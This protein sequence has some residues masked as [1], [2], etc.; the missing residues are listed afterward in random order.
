MYFQRSNRF[1]AFLVALTLAITPATSDAKKPDKPGG[2]NGGGGD[3]GGGDTAAYEYVDLLGFENGS[4]GYQS[5]AK[6]VLNRDGNGTLMILGDSFERYEDL[7]YQENPAIWFVAPDGTFAEPLNL[8]TPASIRQAEPEGFNP[9]G[10]TVVRTKVA[11]EQYDNGDYIF[12]SFVDVLGTGYQELPAFVDRDS[13]AYSINESGTI[14]G[15]QNVW[16]VSRTS[17]RQSRRSSPAR[18]HQ[19]EEKRGSRVGR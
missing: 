7:T 4:L 10:V 5:V 9:V 18:L 1:L 19:I 17:L 11:A 6:Y 13:S 14:V 12:P 16:N 8:G 2:G 15:Y 3:D